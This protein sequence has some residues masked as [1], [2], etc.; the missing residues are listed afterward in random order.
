MLT[1]TDKAAI[2]GL[3]QKWR[4]EASDMSISKP[5]AKY[6]AQQ[7]IGA[8]RAQLNGCAD[9]LEQALQRLLSGET[10]EAVGY[11]V[12]G[13]LGWSYCHEPV[14]GSVPLYTSPHDDAGAV[15][16]EVIAREFIEGM[17]KETIKYRPDNSVAVFD[18]WK[19]GDMLADLLRRHTHAPQ[20]K[21]TAP[22]EGIGDDTSTG[23]QH[24]R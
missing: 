15:D 4:K 2:E 3:I 11:G 24:E 9:E 12:K 6:S 22:T 18:K 23:E 1:P 20:T 8:T 13:P 5:L 7:L 21:P 14:E 19:A 17:S 10:R 16:A